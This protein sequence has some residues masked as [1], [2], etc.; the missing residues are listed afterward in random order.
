MS[1]TYT[2]G[3]M[4]KLASVSIR[5]VQ[6]YDQRGILTPSDLTEGGRRVYS[7][8]DL[9]KLKWICFLRDLDFS[10]KAIQEILVEEHSD[11]VLQLLLERHISELKQ[12]IDQKQV[13]LD[14]AVKLLDKLDK[15]EDYTV[16]SLQDISLIMSNRKKWQALRLQMW[17]RL[18][19]VILFYCLSLVIAVYFNQKWVIWVAIPLFLVTMNAMVYYYKK[20]LSYLCPNCHKT[21]EPSY[22]DFSLAKHTPR[23]RRLTCPHCYVKSSCLELAKED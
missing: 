20:Q 7:D 3:E 17:L 22:L 18:I 21:F 15:Q 10:I 6:Y 12:E 14:T 5:T 19:S 2:T 13:K 16:Y 1:V 23:T 8:K 11:K 4:A 9:E